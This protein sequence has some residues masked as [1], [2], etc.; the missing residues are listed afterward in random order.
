MFRFEEYWRVKHNNRKEKPFLPVE[1]MLK[2]AN[3]S[4]EY[5]SCGAEV[6]T[7]SGA[8]NPE[9]KAPISPGELILMALERIE[10]TQSEL[11]KGLGVSRAM[12]TQMIHNQRGITVENAIAIEDMLH[13]PAHLLLRLQADYNLYRA[14]H[15]SI[16]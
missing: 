1:E 6:L 9:Q 3:L 14:R 5:L 10:L 7:A 11:G 13:I 12:M 16:S 2:A 15:S 4:K 8:N